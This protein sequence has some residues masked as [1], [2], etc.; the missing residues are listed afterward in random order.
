MYVFL[1]TI[2]IGHS[3]EQTGYKHFISFYV[4]TKKKKDSNTIPKCFH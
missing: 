2:K 4:K 1:K 3:K